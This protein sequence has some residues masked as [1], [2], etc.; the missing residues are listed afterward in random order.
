MWPEAR[1]SRDNEEV[2]IWTQFIVL[3]QNLTS[4]QSIYLH[5][6]FL[7]FKWASVSI[8][9]VHVNI[10]N[11]CISL[12]YSL[13]WLTSQGSWIAM[14]VNLLKT[15]Y[16]FYF[17]LFRT[18][19]DRSASLEAAA[20]SSDES[21]KLPVGKVLLLPP[22]WNAIW[23]YMNIKPLDWSFISNKNSINVFAVDCA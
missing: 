11:A 17:L 1:H 3:G 18:R 6:A 14:I 13:K 20:Y 7:F 16:L 15:S 10:A 4:K 8:I 23:M 5:E 9:C 21:S 2:C 22:G 12:W 19:I